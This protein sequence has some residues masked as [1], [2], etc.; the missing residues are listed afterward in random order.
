MTSNRWAISIVS[1]LPTLNSTF[2]RPS[3][4][5][6]I[7]AILIECTSGSIPR[8]EELGKRFAIFIDQPPEPEPTTITL[9]PYS[10]CFCRQLSLG[11]TNLR[12]AVWSNNVPSYDAWPRCSCTFGTSSF[13]K[14]S[15]NRLKSRLLKARYEANP[16]MK[17]ISS[18]SHSRGNNS[19]GNEYLLPLFFNRPSEFAASHQISTGFFASLNNSANSSEEIGSEIRARA[20]NKPYLLP[21]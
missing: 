3:S 14:K 18:S 10:S 11:R 2:L 9:A 8:K 16:P 13:L 5:A 4:S 19:F 6:L 15:S 21:K 17:L 20:V 1:A 12:N 7:L